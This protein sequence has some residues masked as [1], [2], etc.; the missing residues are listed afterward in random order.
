MSRAAKLSPSY[1]YHT[2]ISFP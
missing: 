1:V 2:L